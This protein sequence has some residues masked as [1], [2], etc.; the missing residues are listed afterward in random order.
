MSQNKNVK[1]ALE[2]TIKFAGTLASLLVTAL[3]ESMIKQ[4]K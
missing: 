1:K 3:I 4:D 2:V